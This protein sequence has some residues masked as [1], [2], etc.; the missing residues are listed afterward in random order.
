MA[1][2]E[3]KKPKTFTL[4]LW[5][6]LAYASDAVARREQI[7]MAKQLGIKP[8]QVTIMR[9]KPEDKATWSIEEKQSTRGGVD[10]DEE[11]DEE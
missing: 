2:V 9:M 11:S 4:R 8:E 6:A 3:D 1:K 7:A 10:A 5:G